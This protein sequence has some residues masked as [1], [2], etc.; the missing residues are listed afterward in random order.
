[1]YRAPGMPEGVPQHIPDVVKVGSELPPSASIREQE[2]IHSPSHGWDPSEEDGAGVVSTNARG[3]KQSGS[4][5]FVLAFFVII[6][7][8]V[9]GIF[10]YRYLNLALGIM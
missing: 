10:L 3:A 8:V 2:T 4:G 9:L 6:A 1:V 5:V 7:L